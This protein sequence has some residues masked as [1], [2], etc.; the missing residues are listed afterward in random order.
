MRPTANCDFSSKES[1]NAIIQ[2]RSY[3]SNKVLYDFVR[4]YRENSALGRILAVVTLN[5]IEILVSFCILQ[6]EDSF[7]VPCLHFW[8]LSKN[9]IKAKLS[10]CLINQALGHKGEWRSEG[11]APPF[12]NL[13][14]DGW[15]DR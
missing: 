3:R 13:A 2:E 12:L 8:P 5:S 6:N 15:M 4:R 14:Q 9:K 11:L 1:R 7:V 10:L